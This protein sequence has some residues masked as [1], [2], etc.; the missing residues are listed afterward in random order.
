MWPDGAPPPLPPLQP[1]HQGLPVLQGSKMGNP[2]AVE[3]ASRELRDDALAGR[4]DP[5]DDRR[6]R[7]KDSEGDQDARGEGNG[8]PHPVLFYQVSDE[9][10]VWGAT[11]RILSQFLALLDEALMASQALVIRLRMTRPIS[12]GTIFIF[13]IAVSK[14]V[15]KSA[16]KFLSLARNP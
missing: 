1:P 8:E 14:S 6:G 9:D 13:P 10:L 12:W 5:G 3:F 2:G 11:A 7:E 4:A 15:F 16:L